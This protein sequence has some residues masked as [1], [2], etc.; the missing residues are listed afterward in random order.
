MRSVN[1][2]ISILVLSLLAIILSL[3]LH[4]KAQAQFPPALAPEQGIPTKKTLTVI[5]D[6]GQPIDLADYWQ[7]IPITV[8]VSEMP[9]AV[10][11]HG[12]LEEDAP[13]SS[14]A[15]EIHCCNGVGFPHKRAGQ[16]K[17]WA[18]RNQVML[19][20]PFFNQTNFGGFEGPNGGYRGM[21]GR[22]GRG[23]QARNSDP[24]HVI[25]A[26]IDRY[27]FN[28]PR[29]FR[30]D[31]FIHGHSAGGQFVSRYIIAHPNRVRAAVLS[32]PGSF[33]WPDKSKI[34]ADGASSSEAHR[35][36]RVDWPGS[37]VSRQWLYRPLWWNFIAA[38]RKPIMVSFGRCEVETDFPENCGCL[39][40]ETLDYDAPSNLSQIIVLN[41]PD[42]ILAQF[43]KRLVSSPATE[44]AEGILEGSFKNRGDLVE[45][46][47]SV[48][49]LDA[50]VGHDMIK[51]N[52][53]YPNC[54]HQLCGWSITG[55]GSF[56]GIDL[57]FG[58]DND[59][60]K[61]P[62][63]FPFSPSGY[64]GHLGRGEIFVAAMG[65]VAGSHPPGIILNAVPTEEHY[66]E[67]GT[68]DH[69]DFFNQ[70]LGC[71]EFDD[72]IQDHL[73]NGRVQW[74]DSQYRTVGGNDSVG[75]VLSDRVKIYE[76]YPGF[77]EIVDS[78]HWESI[79]QPKSPI[80]EA[81]MSSQIASQL[82]VF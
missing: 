51:V 74:S 48:D 43:T 72:A 59:C 40:Q 13:D 7:Y 81:W 58:I 34:W 52:A 80:F 64:D 49:C 14:Q 55:T 35:N 26:I 32:S 1:V 31:I 79:T 37:T 36:Y 10:L 30:P 60:L 11:V 54:G 50:F 77:F 3:S 24:D 17:A 23:V 75:S 68:A 53:D 33:A 76:N 47:K 16:W 41:G 61:S 6:H 71:R 65:E 62:S 8:S 42:T 73:N 19:I 57:R 56:A 9:I 25:N 2:R 28:F 39:W 12:S 67:L 15:P 38:A 5:G 46:I 69:I 70:Y 44:N 21:L 82:I 63:D 66:P 78:C 18:D 22:H 29:F 27:V 45:L 4:L 20:C